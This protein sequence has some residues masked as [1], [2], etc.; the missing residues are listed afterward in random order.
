MEMFNFLFNNGNVST[1]STSQESIKVNKCWFGKNAYCS[2]Q[3]IMLVI[4]M[5]RYRQVKHT[6]SLYIK[7]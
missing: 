2:V 3:I 4:R 1:T 7:T 5:D 6:L